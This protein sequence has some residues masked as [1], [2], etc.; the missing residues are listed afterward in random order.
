MREY[1]LDFRAIV[2]CIVGDSVVE[3]LDSKPITD[4]NE[5]FAAVVEEGDGELAT[6]AMDEL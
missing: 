2:D 1:R 5:L 3:R 6:K 4:K